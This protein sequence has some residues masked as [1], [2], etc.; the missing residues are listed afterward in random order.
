MDIRNFLEHTSAHFP[1]SYNLDPFLLAQ[2][3]MFRVSINITRYRSTFFKLLFVVLWTRHSALS[4]SG[5][6]PAAHTY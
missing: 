3:G 6:Y 1:T 4:T 2:L 5:L